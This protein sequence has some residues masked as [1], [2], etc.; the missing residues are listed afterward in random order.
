MRY[1]D[2]ERDAKTQK[3]D[4]VAEIERGSERDDEDDSGEVG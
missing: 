3:T 2:T 4:T 1:D